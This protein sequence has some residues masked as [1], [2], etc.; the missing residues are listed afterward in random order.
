MAKPMPKRMTERQIRKALDRHWAASQAADY[1]REHKIY[2]ADV[3]LDY[4]Q[5]GERIR[6]RDNVRASRGSHPAQRRF[7]VHRIFGSG[8]LWVTELILSY[9]DRPYF[10]ISV[11][12]FTDGKVTHETQYFADPFGAPAWREKWV[13]PEASAQPGG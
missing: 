10:T 5:S 6:G 3:V 4:P 9:D 13:E 7:D 1:E 8:N 2:H 12:E 11:M